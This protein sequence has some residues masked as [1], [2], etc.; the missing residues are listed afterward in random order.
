MN[1]SEILPSAGLR[2]SM[3]LALGFIACLATRPSF[4]QEKPPAPPSTDVVIFKNGD[5]LTGNF[6]RSV[7]D[8]H[9][10]Q[11]R[12]CR[13][14]HHPS[15]QDQRSALERH[16]CRAEEGREDHPPAEDRQLRSSSMTALT[17]RDQWS[18]PETI[19]VKEHR[20]H[21]RRHNLQ[22]GIERNPGPSTVGT[23]PSPAVR[24]CCSPPPF[25]QTFTQECHLFRADS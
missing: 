20:I 21:R 22:Q 19:P 2:R 1:L 17:E 11:E 6:E 25:G 18:S 14:T 23:A 15:G 24:R 8:R 16:F 7:G 13:R 9:H 4:S 12:R 10:L 5:Q 3:C